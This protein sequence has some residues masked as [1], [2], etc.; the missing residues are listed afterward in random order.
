MKLEDSTSF[1][2]QH[3]SINRVFKEYQDQKVADIKK[4]KEL[5]SIF[6]KNLQKHM[7]WEER[8]LF[9]IL[10]K[11][12]HGNHSHAIEIIKDEHR[13]ILQLLRDLYMKVSKNE[14]S[15]KEEENLINALIKHEEF[16]DDVL[17]PAIDMDSDREEAFQ[18]LGDIPEEEFDV[19]C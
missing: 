9:P 6:A 10:A 12:N 19:E 13:K 4:A 18:A 1:E 17:Y 8:V 2:D 14:E 11:D 3:K 15:S 5:F 7:L 16:E